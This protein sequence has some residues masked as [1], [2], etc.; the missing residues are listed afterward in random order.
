MVTIHKNTVRCCGNGN[1][2]FGQRLEIR[3]TRALGQ[4]MIHNKYL[5]LRRLLL[6]PCKNPSGLESS[7]AGGS[8]QQQIITGTG[9]VSDSH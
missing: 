5:A 3:S 2:L 8:E 4:D 6:P 7:S 9:L 1:T